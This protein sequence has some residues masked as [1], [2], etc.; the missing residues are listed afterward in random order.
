[1]KYFE[2]KLDDAE[3]PLVVP[4]V[5]GMD[6]IKF[7]YG[8]P[9]ELVVFKRSGSRFVRTGRRAPT[10]KELDQHKEQLRLAGV[11]VV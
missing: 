9:I 1:M 10:S 11:Q 6:G 7:F 4:V 3:P 2:F 5:D 8:D